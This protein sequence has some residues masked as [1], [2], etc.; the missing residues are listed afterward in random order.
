MWQLTENNYVAC[1]MQLVL[2]SSLHQHNY[3]AW[4]NAV[5]CCRHSEQAWL[6]VQMPDG[7]MHTVPEARGS[8]FVVGAII[9]GRA[10]QPDISAIVSI[11][12]HLPLD[13]GVCYEHVNPAC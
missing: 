9:P 4:C 10:G 7:K 5:S 2:Q 1:R 8:K 3:Y 12:R 13:T 11:M 6:Q